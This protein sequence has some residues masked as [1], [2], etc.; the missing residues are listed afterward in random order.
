MFISVQA[1]EA[2]EVV[3]SEALAPGRID[4]GA[5]ISQSG[6][7]NAKGR[8]EL[9]EEDHGHKQVVRDIRL[10]GDFHG[11]FQVACA[12]CLDPVLT[13][14]DEKFDLLYRPLRAGKQGEEVAI[15]EADTEIG[16]YQGNGVELDDVIKEQVL[17]AM[18][19]RSLC[20]QDCRGLCPHCGVNLNQG[21]CTR[22]TQT[23]DPRWDA[24]QGIRE[25]LKDS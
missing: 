20:Q 5:E 21:S 16:F 19:V 13:A 7:L 12:R 22:Q 14:L 17:L 10:V 23:V 11:Q 1:L 9:I 3:F 2:E 4:F 8:A 6:V 18:P 24:L 25:R 15:N